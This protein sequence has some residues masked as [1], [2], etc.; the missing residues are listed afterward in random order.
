MV[1]SIYFLYSHLCLPFSNTHLVYTSCSTCYWSPSNQSQS[2]DIQIAHCVL[3]PEP[4]QTQ[5]GSV[6][7]AASSSTTSRLLTHFSHTHT[8]TSLTEY[9]SALVSCVYTQSEELTL[10][11]TFVSSS[12]SQI[13][14]HVHTRTHTH[15]HAH[16]H[17]HSHTHA[18]PHTLTHTHTQKRHITCVW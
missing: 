11:T 12:T 17:T 18:H 4:G 15:T 6:Q 3:Q 5:P 7:R 2:P 1:Q 9:W 14:P 13:H 10:E 8:H 16:T